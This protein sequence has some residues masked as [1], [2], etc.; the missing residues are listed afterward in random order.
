MREI[1]FRGKTKYIFDGDWVYGSLYIQCDKY[2][3]HNGRK[4]IEVYK[5][6]IGQFAGLYECA[7]LLYEGDVILTQEGKRK[8]IVF[9]DCA[10]RLAT[11][12]EYQFVMKG[13][14]PFINDY[15]T[16]PALAE[17]SMQPFSLIGN[18]Y[19][20]PELMQDE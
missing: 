18:V 4:W 2:Y 6:T 10:F 17:I 8:V 7:T 16:L 3:I 1:K 19:D 15:T 20:N 13:E 9:D 14:H 11:Q 12:K 5:D